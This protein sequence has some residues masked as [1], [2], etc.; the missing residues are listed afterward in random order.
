MTGLDHKFPNLNYEIWTPPPRAMPIFHIQFYIRKQLKHYINHRS[1][2]SQILVLYV[3]YTIDYY[4]NKLAF[5]KSYY[6]NCD[7]C[8]FLL[9]IE[10]ISSM[11]QFS[12][13]QRHEDMFL[14]I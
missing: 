8:V 3:A 6:K 14:V 1:K 10:V 11:F 9:L 2:L 13:D 4:P 5:I 7:R 12:T